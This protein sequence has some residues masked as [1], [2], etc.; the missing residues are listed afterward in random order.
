MCFGK[1]FCISTPPSVSYNAL[2]LQSKHSL[3]DREHFVI[4]D[5]RLVCLFSTLVA[6][7]RH[8]FTAAPAGEDTLVPPVLTI[9]GNGTSRLRGAVSSRPPAVVGGP[10]PLPSMPHAGEQVNGQAPAGPLT[11][12]TPPSPVPHG[13]VDACPHANARKTSPS[14]L[15]ASGSG[16][17]SWEIEPD[18]CTCQPFWK[19]RDSKDMYKSQEGGWQRCLRG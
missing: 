11:S 8:V 15:K 4:T 12:N 5:S 19:M 1:C 2:P 7:S 17:F 14:H 18:W 9:S 6:A 3:W 13:R 16:I 10:R